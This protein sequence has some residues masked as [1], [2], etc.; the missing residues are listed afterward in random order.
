MYTLQA[1]KQHGVAVL[2]EG[3]K[4][5]GGNNQSG[6]IEISTALNAHGGPAGRLDFESET[7]IASPAVAHTL[8]GEGS[9]SSEDG[10]PIAFHGTQD[11]DISGDVTHPL[12]LNYGQEN[13]IAFCA[14]D[15]GADAGPIS[16]TLRAGGFDKSHANGGVMPA[17]MIRMRVRRL[18]PRECE[19]LQGFPDDYTAIIYRYKYAYDGPRYKCLGNSWAVPNARWIGKRI[20]VVQKIINDRT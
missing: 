16:P 7:F 5:F 3:P 8:R 11:P 12:G 15:Y 17:V 6:P 1:G 19:R 13:A 4:A 9:D 18:T 14:K 20:D 10:T 2:Q